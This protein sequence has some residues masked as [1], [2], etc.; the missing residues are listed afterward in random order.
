MNQK[1]EDLTSGLIMNLGIEFMKWKQENADK[2]LKRLQG[3]VFFN[4]LS[5]FIVVEE[6]KLNSESP[7]PQGGQGGY[8]QKMR[9]QR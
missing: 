1:Q 6:R 8:L 5:P 7:I 9:G 4:I 3:K 2:G